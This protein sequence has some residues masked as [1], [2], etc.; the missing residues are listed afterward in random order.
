MTLS[1][2][3]EIFY[4]PS[5]ATQR[6]GHEEELREGSFSLRESCVFPDSRLEHPLCLVLLGLMY[7]CMDSQREEHLRFVSPCEN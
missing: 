6:Q 2:E 3:K 7:F 1:L 5:K 4:F